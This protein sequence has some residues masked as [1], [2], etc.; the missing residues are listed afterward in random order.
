MKNLFNFLFC[1]VALFSLQV[2]ANAQFSVEPASTKLP[3]LSLPGKNIPSVLESTVDVNKANIALHNRKT[4]LGIAH[5]TV[6]LRA[7]MDH[8]NPGVIFPLELYCRAYTKNYTTSWVSLNCISKDNYN[9]MFEYITNF[10][11]SNNTGV[12]Q[13]I[14]VDFVYKLWSP[15]LK[16]TIWVSRKSQVTLDSNSN[17]GTI[18]IGNFR[19]PQAFFKP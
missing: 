16:K 9:T 4:S 8:N 14:T 3:N 5:W 11:I 15:S 7:E 1:F 2:K 6:G 17:S 10:D 12:R 13:S 18:N 19:R